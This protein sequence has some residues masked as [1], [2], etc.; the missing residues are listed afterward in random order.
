MD[1][2]GDRRGRV[3]STQSQL[4]AAILDAYDE[5]RDRREQLTAR[6]TELGDEEPVAA[7]AAYDLPP[8]LER[9]S[10]AVDSALRVEQSC[11]ATYA[12]AVAETSGDDRAW[13]ITAL[14][15][16]AVREAVVR[17]GP[18][19]T[20]PAS[21]SSRTADVFTPAARSGPTHSSRPT[22]RRKSRDLPG[23]AGREPVVHKS[24]TGGTDVNLRRTAGLRTA[25]TC[26][27]QD[28]SGQ[29]NG[30][31]GP[32]PWWLP[33]ARFRA[34]WGRVGLPNQPGAADFRARARV[35]ARAKGFPRRVRTW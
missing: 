3:E 19:V 27:S 5:H 18:G 33:W 7:A 6:I 29:T 22:M 25:R 10:A 4:R 8:G 35:R 2:V 30:W 13:A 23:V 28:R 32:R 15:E 9:A 12:A 14:R 17:R 31:T 24:A 26:R 1:A 20:S 16:S 34:A 21:T 11:A